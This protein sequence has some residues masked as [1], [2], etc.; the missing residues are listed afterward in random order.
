MKAVFFT[1]HGNL[2]VLQYG[3]LPTPV[4]KTGEVLVRLKVAAL[5]RLD[6]WVR[7]GWPGLRLDLPHI[8]GAD[9]AGWVE[10]IGNGVTAVKEGMAVVI[11]PNIG[12][13]N[14]LEC[15]AGQDNRCRNWHLLGET[16]PGTYAEY[17]VVPER[18]VLP[19][20]DA[21]PMAEA[22]AAALVFQTAWHSLITRGQ[23]RAGESVLIVGA[24][25]GVNTASIQIAKLAGAVVFVVGSSSE[26]LE[27]A[28]SLGADF[29]IDRS[30]EE[31]WA[32]VVYQLTDREGVDVVVDNV[33]ITFSMSFRAARK[34]GRILTVGNTGGAVFEIDN[35]YVFG[36]HL[37]LIGSTMGNQR[38]F[39]QVMKLIFEGKLRAVI[40][41][42]YPLQEARM[43]QE[44]LE[45]GR[46]KGKILLEV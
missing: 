4:P 45:S 46:Q 28:K 35:R 32:K 14:C 44:R 2:E 38:D 13:G 7:R 43:A 25:G 21:F 5:N 16:L 34:G 29:L 33:G 36:K 23:L 37:S 10:A 9:G 27:L 24:S 1:Q 8:P 12:C 41:R 18:N 26:K 31:N 6:L 19:L 39:R 17:V 30:Q 40:D 3:D 42:I 20:P 22:A 15:L 11:N